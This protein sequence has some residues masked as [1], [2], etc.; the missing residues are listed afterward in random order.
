MLISEAPMRELA[1][2]MWGGARPQSQLGLEEI[3]VKPQSEINRS[4][5]GKDGG[6]I[7]TREVM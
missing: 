2:D 7:G 4:A 1:N 5:L 3:P 6:R